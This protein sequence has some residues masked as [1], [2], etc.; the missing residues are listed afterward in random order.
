[1]ANL[2]ISK[3]NEIHTQIDRTTCEIDRQE[4]AIQTLSS[5]KANFDEIKVADK[6]TFINN[7]LTKRHKKIQELRERLQKLN[8]D[9]EQVEKGNYDFSNEMKKNETTYERAREQSKKSLGK[10]TSSRYLGKSKQNVPVKGVAYD[11]NEQESQERLRLA[12][13][14]FSDEDRK[15]K[16]LTRDF[17]YAEEHM[18][19][20]MDKMSARD[21]DYLARIPNNEGLIL[22]GIWYF[23]ARPSNSETISMQNPRERTLTKYYTNGCV[24]IFENRQLS[25][26]FWRR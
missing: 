20:S 2:R 11:A 18:R 26:T 16:R 25:Q 15:Q 24:E 5:N 22:D 21:R 3:I 12:T 4:T 13:S 19:R 1:M 7:E 8:E 23:G 10:Q 14:R 17:A 9:L 6:C